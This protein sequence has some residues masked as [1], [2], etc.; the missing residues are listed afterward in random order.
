MVTSSLFPHLAE[1]MR[2]P[3]RHGLFLVL[4]ALLAF[5][6][7]TWLAP[8]VIVVCLGVPLLFALYVWQSGGYRDVSP[9]VLVSAIG[10][11]AAISAVWW[12]WS[13]ALVAREY[14]IP[15]AAGSQ[16]QRELTL[17]LVVTLVGIGLM[18]S[19][20]VVFRIFHRRVHESLDG[21]VI[22]AACA[23]VYSA[24]GTIAWLAPQFAVG[25]ID[26][27]VPWRLFEE[28]YLYGFVDMVTSAVAG[29][30]LGLRLWFR[31]GSNAVTPGLARRVL[32]V[33]TLAAIAIYVGV[34]LV[35][36]AE[37]S[38]VTEVAAN[39][40]LTAVSL[41]LLRAG[42]QVALLHGSADPGTGQPVVCEDCGRTIADRPFC[43]GCGAAARATSRSSRAL[44]F[45]AA[46]RDDA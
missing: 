10:V 45:A 38:R 30:L 32:D 44:R 8:L 6:M 18:L 20:I 3:F 16:L 46:G 23:L 26:N 28:A 5:S 19:T 27:Y 22:G 43:P 42:I 12:V 25:L 7:L 11:A 40:V 1:S 34:Y 35:D 29:G 9:T 4:G 17:G 37:T 15:V 21:F 14:D 24:A 41:V 33:L 2:W 31:P 13:G 39:T 36:A